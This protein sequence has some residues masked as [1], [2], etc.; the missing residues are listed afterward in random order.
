MSLLMPMRWKFRKQRRWRNKGISNRWNY[1]AFGEFWM[2]ALKN[3]Y[4]TNRQLEA[5][6][7]VIIRYIRKT[8]KLWIRIFPD[9]PYTK[10][11][12]EMPMGKWKG[13]V[14]HYRARVKRWRIIFEITGVDR[15]TA[16]E[17]FKQAAYKLP[18]QYK[19]VER[20]EIR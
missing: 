16:E 5:A 20:G 7:K 11:W 4:I 14:D 18:G 2:K 12:L 10:K 9:I 8:W 19:L 6:R 1:V 17:A 3:V 15:E 13:D